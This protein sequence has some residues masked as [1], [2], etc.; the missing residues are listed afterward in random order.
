[1]HVIVRAKQWMHTHACVAWAVGHF[2]GTLGTWHEVL[3][4]GA[5]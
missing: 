4:F 3:E 2:D 5:I 1:V